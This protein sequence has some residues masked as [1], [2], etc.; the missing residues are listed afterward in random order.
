MYN[1]LE[2]QWETIKLQERHRQ[3]TEK[4]KIFGYDSK[5]VFEEIQAL[6]RDVDELERKTIETMDELGIN[7]H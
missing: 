5:E 6:Q 7:K 1:A 4:A 3:L 2:L